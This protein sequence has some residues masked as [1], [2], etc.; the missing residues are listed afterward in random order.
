MKL[1]EARDV[2][3]A[4]AEMEASLKRVQR[5]YLSHAAQPADATR[6]AQN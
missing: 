5:S 6:T 2:D 3:G 1:M 4:I